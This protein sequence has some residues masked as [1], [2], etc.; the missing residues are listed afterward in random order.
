MYKSNDNNAAIREIKKYLYA[1]NQSTYPS[2]RRTTVDGVYDDETRG[3][4]MDFQ[5]LMALEQTGIV[6]YETFT[7]LYSEY[8]IALE[9]KK[10]DRITSGGEFPLSI[11]DMNEDVRLLHI[12]INELSRVYSSLGDVGTSSYYSSD[13]AD[14]ILTLSRIYMMEE[15]NSTDRAMMDRITYDV[16][17][18]SLMF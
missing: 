18:N 9:S 8:L 15:T 2:I 4:V 6:D 3:A 13:T 17:N 11:G 14:A 7:L 5:A 12:Y 1:L 10:P 16:W